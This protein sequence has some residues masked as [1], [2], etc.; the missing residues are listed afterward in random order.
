MGGAR[1]Y[2]LSGETAQTYLDRYMPMNAGRIVIPDEIVDVCGDPVIALDELRRWQSR[3]TDVSD[4]IGLGNGRLGVKVYYSAS[5]D[6][7]Q[8][9]IRDNWK[10]RRGKR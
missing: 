4:L 10:K 8:V 1:M 2:P 7:E 9:V 5:Q 3:H 6:P